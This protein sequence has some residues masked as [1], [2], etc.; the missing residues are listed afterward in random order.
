[1]RRVLAGVAGGL[2]ASLLILWVAGFA[3]GSTATHPRLVAEDGSAPLRRIAIHYAPAADRVA[4]G[5]W[6]QLFAVLPARVEVEVEVAEA[7]DFDRLLVKL[8]EA[9]VA[10]LDRFHP[11]VV[12]K[13]IT[14]WSR[15]RYAALVNDHGEGSILAPPRIE[16]PFASRAGDAHSPYAISQALYHRDPGVA[17]IV[18]EG[19]DLAATPRWI[20]ADA[21]LVARNVGRGA[22]DRASIE[23]ELHRRFSQ[24]LVWLG[25]AVGDVPR[26]HIMMYAVPLDDQTVAVGDVRAGTQLAG[27]TR[28]P[29]DDVAL[30]APRFDRAAALLAA[31][32]FQ[33]VR[34]PALVLE[35]GGSFVT[36]TN[37]L[38]DRRADGRRVVYMPTYAL[39][40]LDQAAQRFYEAQGFEVHP[41]DV[42]PIYRL[43]GSLGCL[44]N[45]IAR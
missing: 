5:V 22:A 14:T 2:V 45:V 27:E 4:L 36:Y 30:Q 35:G 23:S 3:R 8:H 9:G 15:D 32:G 6:N 7:P 38:F 33:V 18:F 37:A 34:V 41:I 19:G 26:H 17:D 31:H 29:L 39:P 28:L 13:T 1:M 43:N 24:E 10:H 12:G 42:S 44:V 11:V 16:T 25:D 21:N 40:A 20:F